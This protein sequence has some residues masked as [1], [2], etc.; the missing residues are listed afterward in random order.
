MLGNL[1]FAAITR[2][3]FKTVKKK[4]KLL[5]KQLPES[6]DA[7]FELI[8]GPLDDE[9]P[10][11]GD[12]LFVKFTDTDYTDSVRNFLLQHDHFAKLLVTE[13]KLVCLSRDGGKLAE[14][15]DLSCKI[16]K[17]YRFGSS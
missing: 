17:I 4:I 3:L 5:T 8:G 10:G 13:N 16:T 2:G 11:N 12:L 6:Y 1:F 15:P 14:V 7:V 9:A